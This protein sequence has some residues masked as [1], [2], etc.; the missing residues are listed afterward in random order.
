MRLY[1]RNMSCSRYDRCDAT[2]GQSRHNTDGT[3]YCQYCGCY[4]YDEQHGGRKNK[5]KTRGKKSRS[6]K[7]RK[8]RR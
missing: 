3:G 6:K 8:S 1:Y 2:N 5:R 7:T 4:M